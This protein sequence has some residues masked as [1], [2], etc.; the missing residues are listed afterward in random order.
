[1]APSQYSQIR[2]SRTARWVTNVPISESV[3]FPPE[4]SALKV[5]PSKAAILGINDASPCFGT[6]SRMT[7]ARLSKARIS[8]DQRR[9]PLV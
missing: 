2:L 4:V 1:M 5:R 9:I 6:Q 8:V 7:S 3:S